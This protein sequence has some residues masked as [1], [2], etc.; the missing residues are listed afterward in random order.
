MSESKIR[1][2]IFAE[3]NDSTEKI[4]PLPERRVINRKASGKKLKFRSL[5]IF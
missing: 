1:L 5:E 2:N 3:I 4:S